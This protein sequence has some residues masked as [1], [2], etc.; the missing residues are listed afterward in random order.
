MYT[1]LDRFLTELYPEY[2]ESAFYIVGESYGGH[3]VPTTAY[4]IF[5]NRPSWYANM[6]GFGI[7]NPGIENDWFDAA[8]TLT[9]GGP[10]CMQLRPRVLPPS[11]AGTTT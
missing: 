8:T 3:Y 4:E 7:G 1:F 10:G 6:K 9:H 5:K 2:L 11:P